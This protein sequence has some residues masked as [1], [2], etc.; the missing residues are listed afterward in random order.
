MICSYISFLPEL[1]IKLKLYEISKLFCL[2]IDN[3]F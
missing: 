2:L 1:K 3:N